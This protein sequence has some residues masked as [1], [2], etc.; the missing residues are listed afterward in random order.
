MEEEPFAAIPV[1]DDGIDVS[2]NLPD[3]FPA[4]DQLFIEHLI[5]PYW[6]ALQAINRLDPIAS[7][8]TKVTDEKESAEWYR[9]YEE[10]MLRDKSEFDED[11][12][13]HQQFLSLLDSIHDDIQFI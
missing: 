2:F 6:Y 9:Y 4:P 3:D 11:G 7:G 10:G 1:I 12:K 8:F 13:R 5:P